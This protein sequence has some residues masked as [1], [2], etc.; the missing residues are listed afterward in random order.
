MAESTVESRVASRL[1]VGRLGVAAAITVVVAG[2]AMG[3][4]HQIWPDP[5]GAAIPPS[6]LLPYFI[7]L[8]GLGCLLLGMGV[9]FLV[10]GYGLVA[11]A[12]QP[13]ALTYATYLSIAWLMVSWW[14]HGNLHRVT[15]GANWTGLLGIDYGFHLT[16]MGASIIVA[17]FFLRVLGQPAG[18]R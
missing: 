8:D 10:F 14:P 3:L 9:S 17:I 2:L 5:V 4:G 12:G 1:S 7:V 15:V 16:L 13:L 11:R 18:Q 6:T